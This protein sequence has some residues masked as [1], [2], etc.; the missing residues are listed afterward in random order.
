MGRSR[1]HAG[2]QALLADV[3][4]YA[5]FHY[6]GNHMVASFPS[7]G[8]TGAYLYNFFLGPIAPIG[9]SPTPGQSVSFS[10]LT[11]VPNSTVFSFRYF[12]SLAIV[13]FVGGVGCQA[14]APGASR[15]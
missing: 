12:N 13:F 15:W 11:S 4:A 9:D 5:S 8:V 10:S 7:E 1:H 6:C 14:H 3:Y 2:R